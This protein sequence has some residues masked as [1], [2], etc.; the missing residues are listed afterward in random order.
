MKTQIVTDIDS[1]KLLF[2]HRC[3]GQFDDCIPPQDG[4]YF[5]KVMYCDYWDSEWAK[6]G[7][8]HIAIICACPQAVTDKEGLCSSMGLKLDEFNKSFELAQAEMAIDYGNSATLWQEQG[9]NLAKLMRAARAELPKITM[10]SG[11]YLD[12]AQNAI[13]NSGWDFV[14]GDIGFKQ[15]K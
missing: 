3:E 9:N 11:F 1:H 2:V 14:K 15:A 10:M 5:I 8:Y 7:K 13:G 12:R 4:L 6:T